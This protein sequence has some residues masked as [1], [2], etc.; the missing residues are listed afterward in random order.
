MRVIDGGRLDQP[1]PVQVNK[2]FVEGNF[3]LVIT[4]G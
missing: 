2:I 3:D 4:P 1:L